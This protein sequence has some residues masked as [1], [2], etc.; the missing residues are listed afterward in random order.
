MCVMKVTKHPRSCGF[1][2][3][4]LLFTA[5]AAKAK[6]EYTFTLVADTAGPFSNFYFPSPS[7]S[8][9]GTVAFAAN[10]DSGRLGIFAGNGGSVT[11]IALAALPNG[12]F[13]YPS[14][15]KAGTVAFSSTQGNGVRERIVAAL[16]R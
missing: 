11:T 8:A 13:G 12:S 7:L 3:V 15:N 2:I 4:C 10:L 16:E 14:I 1:F 6:A 5:T 9:A